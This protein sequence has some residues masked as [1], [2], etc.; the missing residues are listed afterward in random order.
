VVGRY[1]LPHEILSFLEKCTPD[2]NGEIQLTEALDKLSKDRGFVLNAFLSDSNIFDC[3]TKIGFIGANITRAMKE[4]GL[5][6][7]IREIID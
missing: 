3:G 2:K 1:V 7:Y 6:K 5:K 4:K